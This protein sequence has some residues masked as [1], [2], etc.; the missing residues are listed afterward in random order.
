MI[1]SRLA[2]VAVVVLAAGTML[3]IAAPAIALP[4][5][6]STCVAGAMPPPQYTAPCTPTVTGTNPIPSGGGSVT[7]T[8]PGV[9]SIVITVD[10]TGNL[11]APT[12]TPMA[13]FKMGT[14]K[15]NNDTG[16]VSVTFTNK[17][18]PLPAGVKPETYVIKAKVSQLP[19]TAGYAVQTIAKPVARHKDDE[20]SEGNNSD[21]KKNES[22]DDQG[23]AGA[24]GAGAG[25]A[26]HNTGFQ[27]E[28]SSG[29]QGGGG[30]GQ[31]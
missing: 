2:G 28:G 13:P 18:A 29:H 4:A 7:L 3:A 15:V 23:G 12:V 6:P 9:G 25:G 19:G 26:A 10:A 5:L 8:L 30:G 22:N 14:L 31:D 21:G 24:G 27:G 17:G 1:R 20:D 16:L 11:T